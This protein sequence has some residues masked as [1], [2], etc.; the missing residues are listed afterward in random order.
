L[1][2]GL[3]R[4][5]ED[6][7]K[8]FAAERV[9]VGGVAAKSGGRGPLPDAASL[10]NRGTKGNKLTPLKEEEMPSLKQL[11]EATKIDD[12]QDNNDANRRRHVILTKVAE[13]ELRLSGAPQLATDTTN[14]KRN[15]VP[16]SNL[17]N[18]TTTIPRATGEIINALKRVEENELSRGA[19]AEAK[20]ASELL[21]RATKLGGHFAAAQS[22][23]EKYRDVDSSHLDN[24]DQ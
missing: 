18:S 12:E 21:K 7:A 22:F 23:A 8:R 3:Q 9:K 17:A 16:S 13:S 20:L 10:G 4:V 1:L 24:I 19:D 15:S 5:D 11:G 14:S 6:P 2:K